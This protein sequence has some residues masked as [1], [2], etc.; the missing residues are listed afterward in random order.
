MP[1]S[2]SPGPSSTDAVTSEI[3][4]RPSAEQSLDIR[5]C[6]FC[7]TPLRHLVVD[8]GLQPLCQSRVLRED[9]NKYE[10][11]YPLRA[12]VCD[13]CWLMQVH[14]HVGGEAIFSEYAYFSSYADSWVAHARRYV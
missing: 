1:S 4:F 14:E 7:G 10:V 3:D 13:R 2:P 11:C 6:R 5:G 9:L 12:Y 8:L